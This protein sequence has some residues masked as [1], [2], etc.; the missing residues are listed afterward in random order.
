MNGIRAPRFGLKEHQVFWSGQGAI[1]CACCHIPYPGSDTG[2]GSNGRRSRP[3][4]WRRSIARA[5]VSR[6]KAA[7][8]SRAGSCA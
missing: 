1:V 3:R 8:E 4:S 5:G 6:A 2:C 7:A